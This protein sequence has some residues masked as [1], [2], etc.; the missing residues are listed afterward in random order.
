MG[1]ACSLVVLLLQC[2]NILCLH[3]VNVLSLWCVCLFVCVFTNLTARGG[4]DTR[5]I[6][7]AELSVLRFSFSTTGCHI[8]VKDH[9]LPNYLPI[10]GEKVHIFPR[11]LTLCEMQIA[12]SKIWTQVTVLISYHSDYYITSLP[13]S[14]SVAQL[15]RAVEYTDCTSAEG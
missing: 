4:W 2:R 10:A 6:L 5:S 3:L 9:S 8:K 12:S 14:L 15:A 1:L 11:V 13:F 7:K